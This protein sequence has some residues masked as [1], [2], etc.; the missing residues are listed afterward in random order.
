M[1]SFALSAPL[2]AFAFLRDLFGVFAN[3]VRKVRGEVGGDYLWWFCH[4][5]S[6]MA[7]AGSV[8]SCAIELNLFVLHMFMSVKIQEGRKLF[9]TCSTWLGNRVRQPRRPREAEHVNLTT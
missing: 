9:Y 1:A 2:F 3:G 5:Y 4:C 6:K 7:R 8:G